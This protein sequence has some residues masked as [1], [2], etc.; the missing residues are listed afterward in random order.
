MACIFPYIFTNSFIQ[1]EEI[2]VPYE[3]KKQFDRVFSSI[4]PSPS[5]SPETHIITP[6]RL[7]V[8]SEVI[9]QAESSESYVA[10]SHSVVALEDWFR[11]DGLILR[12][13]STYE[14]PRSAL[15]PNPPLPNGTA[16]LGLKYE[17]LMTSPVLQGY[18]CPSK[19]R[20][21]LLPPLDEPFGNGHV[22]SQSSGIST[23]TSD[24]LS[25][26]G[27]I[28]IDEN[29]LVGSVSSTFPDGQDATQ[30]PHH[31]SRQSHRFIAEPLPGLVH[32]SDE[33]TVYLRTADLS[34]LGI[35]D[36][37]WV[38]GLRYIPL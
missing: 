30:S 20:F 14:L 2:T 7:V 17:L 31:S 13:Q 26:D 4:Y 35:L 33:H 37:D 29:F 11:R 5:G 23:P 19:T 25:V 24:A 36:A 38:S 1:D 27:D 22:P 3:W 32:S 9:I 18:A 10:A 21:V 8:L 34:R 16:S 6:A 12:Q 28:E 15:V